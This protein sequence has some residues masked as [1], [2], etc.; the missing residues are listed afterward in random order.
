MWPI[1]GL[2]CQLTPGTVFRIELKENHNKDCLV[3]SIIGLASRVPGHVHIQDE[4]DAFSVSEEKSRIT[5][6][7]ESEVFDDFNKLLAVI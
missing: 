5:E 4:G 2:C 3:F 7:F 6:K 1:S